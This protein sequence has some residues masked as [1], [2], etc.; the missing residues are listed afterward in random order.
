MKQQ[1][2]GFDVGQDAAWVHQAA[3]DG[4]RSHPVCIDPTPVVPNLDQQVPGLTAQADAHLAIFRLARRGALVDGFQPMVERIAEQVLQGRLQP[5]KHSA[6]DFD[7]ITCDIEIRQF[8]QLGAQLAHDAVQTRHHA[9]KGHHVGAGEPLLQFGVEPALVHQQSFRL[10]Q[11]HAQVLAQIFQIRSALQKRPRQLLQLGIAVHFEGIELTMAP[12]AALAAQVHLR[13][14]L[15]IQ[16]PQLVPQ[17]QD[18]HV[19]FFE[20]FAAI[21]ELLFD[22]RPG[23]A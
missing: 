21:A 1:A 3:F 2:A 11:P 22:P 12:L 23:N 5:F 13:L 6:V 17:A 14:S 15:E 8:A 10:L 18:G 4:P 7:A 20:G 9:G 19:H 16:S